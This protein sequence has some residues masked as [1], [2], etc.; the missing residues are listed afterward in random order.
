M[1]AT[2]LRDKKVV[3]PDGSIAQIVVWKL[4]QTSPQ[5]PHGYKYR[6]NYCTADGITRVRYDNETGKGDHKHINDSELP[7]KF[8][9]LDKLFQDFADDVS[10]ARRKQ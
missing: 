7:Y 3:Y 4:P 8:E 2:L 5:R 6:L 9:S 10:R 1:E